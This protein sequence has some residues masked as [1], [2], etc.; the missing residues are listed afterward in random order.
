MA[1]GAKILEVTKLPASASVGLRVKAALNGKGSK[2]GC[3]L[4][5][6]RV[7]P[8]GASFRIQKACLIPR[9]PEFAITTGPLTV[10]LGSDS[11]KCNC[12]FCVIV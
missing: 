1:G 9:Q 3:Y 8:D 7:A 12:P 11:K 10:P 2:C 4:L 5:K 6:A